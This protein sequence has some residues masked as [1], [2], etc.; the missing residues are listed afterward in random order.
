VGVVGYVAALVTRDGDPTGEMHGWLAALARPTPLHYA[1]VGT[2]ASVVGHWTCRRW[3]MADE[4]PELAD[5][6]A[7]V[8]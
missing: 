4:P 7:P 8:V 3:A 1:S 6:D 5:A 2:A